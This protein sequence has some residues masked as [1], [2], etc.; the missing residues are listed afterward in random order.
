MQINFKNYAKKILFIFEQLFKTNSLFL[1]FVTL[2]VLINGLNPV[3]TSYITSKII[4]ILETYGTTSLSDQYVHLILLIALMLISVVLSLFTSSI[5]VII[6]EL[7]S[8]QITHNIQNAVA[9]HFNLI[10]Q[11]TIDTPEFQNLYKITSEKVLTAPMSV[12]ETLF[13]LISCI[14]G[15]LGYISILLTLHPLSVIFMLGIVIP[16]Y[17]LRKKSLTLDFNFMD[18]HATEL[19]QIAYDYALLAD[20]QSTKE[21]RTL[22]LLTYLKESR[23]K[24]FKDLMSISQK[25]A[26]K[27]YAYLIFSTV[28][29]LLGAFGSEYILIHNLI[30]GNI[31]IS[32]FVF[33]NTAITSLITSLFTFVDLTIFNDQSLLFLDYLFRFLEI[34]TEDK[35]I[36]QCSYNNELTTNNL[37]PNEYVYE[38]EFSD[39]TFAYPGATKNSLE[40]ITFKFH[41]G[42]KVCLVGENGSG[43]STLLK[44][45]LKIY[46]PTEG[47]ILINGCDICNF[48]T[49]SYRKLFGVIFQ[50]FIHYFKTVQ[51]NI[52]FGDVDKIEN[53]E[54]IENTAR[55]TKS[56]DFIKKYKKGYK[57][58]LGKLFFGE[59][60]MPSGGQWQKLAISR[61][62]FPDSKI[63][64]LDEPTASLDPKAEDE[65]F[66]MFHEYEK[67]KAIFMVSHRMCSAKLAD[68]IILLS[69]GKIVEYGSHEELM[70][71]KKLYFEMYSLQ[72]E[73]YI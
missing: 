13:G 6:S 9:E 73:K 43:K 33:Y 8:K 34:P 47:K 70:T 42:E 52:G 30:K 44:L 35:Y 26:R 58:D 25:N 56:H 29:F 7:T 31:P 28:L 24:K 39:V 4:Y 11:R 46:E 48:D 50:D 72:A 23:N 41:T 27:K 12:A 67:D 21:I 69:D 20:N 10:P 1:F 14:V 19:R 68:K 62:F 51:E 32:Q 22:G 18:N 45:L 63:L 38:I 5:K 55:I 37:N 57:T 17:F 49:D 54:K 40:H 53:M 65:I 2:V 66:Q 3:F 36:S 61:A 59:G 16:I 60:I 64:V 71:K 15:M